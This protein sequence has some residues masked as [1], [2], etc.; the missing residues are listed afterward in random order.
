MADI[1]VRRLGHAWL[2]FVLFLVC[3]FNYADRTVVASIAGPLRQDL[4]L[5]DF[6]IGLLQGLSFALLYC[7]LGLPFARLAERRSRVKILACAVTAWSLATVGCGA[8]GSFPQLMLARTGVGIGEAG[9]MGPAQSL[10]GDY[11]PAKKRAMATSWM[12]MGVP[13]GA[14]IGATAGGFIAQSWGWRWA[15]VAMGLPGLLVA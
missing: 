10:L 6:H 11:F 9:F 14:L 1:P 3:L 5:T 15:F 4:G 7:L 2:L 8:A 12:M 13:V